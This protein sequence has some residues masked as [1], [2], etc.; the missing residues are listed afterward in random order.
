MLNAPVYRLAEFVLDPRHQLLLLSGER[1]ELARKPYSILLYLVENRDRLITRQELLDRF[2]DGKEVY[3][4][5]LTRAVA[6]I[7]SALGDSR[8]E[9]RFLETRWAVGYRYIGPFEETAGTFAPGAP[10]ST[11]APAKAGVSEVSIAAPGAPEAPFVR[12]LLPA[13]SAQI[14]ARI[15]FPAMVL[16]LAAATVWFVRHPARSTP[17]PALVADSPQAHLR[18]AIAILTF[19]NLVG[20]AD[21]EWLGT[22]LAEMLS[23]DLAGDGRVR[24]LPGDEVDRALRELGIGRTLGLSPPA[25]QAVNRD[26]EADLVITGS[27]VVLDSGGGRKRVR[28]D[29]EEQDAKSGET[30]AAFSEDGRLDT[31]FDIASSAESRLLASMK[32]PS[33]VGSA[34]ASAA[35]GSTSPEAFREYMG[36]LRNLRAESFSAAQAHLESAVAHDRSFPLAHVA[37]ADLWTT[38]GYQQRERA[39]L[40]TA[41]GLTGRLGREQSLAVHARYAASCGDWDKAIQNYQALFTFF[42]DNVDYGIQLS[43]MQTAAGRTQ[44][45][46]TTL[47]ALRRLPAP[48]R[49]DLRIDLAEATAAQAVSDADGTA[50]A[51]QHAMDKAKAS[52]AMLLYAH[53]LSMQAGALARSDLVA[54]VRESQQAG[55]ICAQFHDLECSANILRRIGIFKVDSDPAGAT[56]ALTEALGIARTIGNRT[57]EDNDLNGLA[58]IFSNRGDF[59]AADEMYREVLRHAREDGAGWGMQMAMNNLGDDLLV[60]GKVAEARTLQQG[61]LAISQRIG[62]KEAAALELLSLSQI[63]LVEG[64]VHDAEGHAVQAKNAF[65]KLNSAS[66]QASAESLLGDVERE[67][68]RIELARQDE[69]DA[70]A[71]FAKAGDVGSLAEARLAQAQIAFAAGDSGEASRLAREAAIDL[72]R[73]NRFAEEGCAHALLGLA[74][75]GKGQYDQAQIEIGRGLALTA[76]SQDRLSSLHVQIDAALLDA[77]APGGKRTADLEEASRRIS[78]LSAEA[79]R[80][81]MELLAMR[82]K[83]AQAELEARCGRWKEGRASAKQAEQLSRQYGYFLLA[84]QSSKLVRRIDASE[85]NRPAADYSAITRAGSQ[86]DK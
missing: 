47:E 15:A 13:W 33:G 74:L 17:K 65:Q 42:P 61:A 25:L 51:T 66:E 22:A 85:S 36:G 24:T 32:L 52:G 86:F 9:P 27:Y 48:L 83:L 58:T 63:D 8:E 10:Q 39:E 82:A 60:E 40:K 68:N 34:E 11:A 30:V 44:E 57:E 29:V 1:V 16:T 12:G 28:V 37:L 49:D 70:T 31:L 69:T 62:L 72:H 50:R 71:I 75:A 46:R 53:A 5:T 3:D 23:T 59:K 79:E 35:I 43:H 81:G 54:S 26:L 73:Q 4:Q 38:L 64:N 14:A 67:G 56:K 18:K 41:D 84:A 20:N 78:R 55:A 7:R 45:A 76:G 80:D 21:S 6:R 19:R 77:R 2:W